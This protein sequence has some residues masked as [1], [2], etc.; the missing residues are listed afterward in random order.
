MGA[1]LRET[2]AL[3]ISVTTRAIAA[4][5]ALFSIEAN[6]SLHSAHDS[7]ISVRP[8]TPLS[9]SCCRICS[10]FSRVWISP[11]NALAWLY[12]WSLLLESTLRSAVIDESSGWSWFS[13]AC[14]RT[15]SAWILA[16]RPYTTC[17]H[18]YLAFWLRSIA[19]NWLLRLS[20]YACSFNNW[21]RPLRL[22]DLRSSYT[23]R[24]K[25]NVSNFMANYWQTSL[26]LVAM[27]VSAD[28]ATLRRDFCNWPNAVGSV[29][30]SHWDVHALL[31]GV[32]RWERRLHQ[33]KERRNIYPNLQQALLYPP[34]P[35]Q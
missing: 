11:S 13:S 27:E 28:L 32:W 30:K 20:L 1:Y 23:S 29:G 22:D 15:I 17:C 3:I 18:Y 5:A 25:A 21:F 24:L 2:E 9:T 14:S 4:W 19:W 10:L 12:S 16:I 31:L 7:S 35:I 33:L 34:T 8:C 26:T 6:S